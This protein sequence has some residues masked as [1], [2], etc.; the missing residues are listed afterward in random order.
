MFGVAASV[1]LLSILGVMVPWWGALQNYR[2]TIETSAEQVAS[3]RALI[4]SE[5]AVRKAKQ[6]FAAARSDAGL[7]IE[8][9]NADLAAA[10]LQTKVKE[11]VAASGGTLVS[12]QNLPSSSQD[13][14]GKVIVR[15]RMKGDVDALAKVLYE[16]EAHRPLM[17]VDDLDIRSRK[18]VTGRR[19]QRRTVFSLDADFN[20]AAFH[21]GAK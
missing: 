19:G 17:L 20:L 21:W 1:L 7:F 2:S 6:E 10:Q 13:D 4:A 8:A 3:Y 12:T 11:I 15:V 9:G 14:P 18:T 16:V 5:S